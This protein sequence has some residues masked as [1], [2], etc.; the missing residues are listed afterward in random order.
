MSDSKRP[1]RKNALCWTVLIDVLHVFRSGGTP[2]MLAAVPADALGSV[3]LSDALQK[4]PTDSDIIAE[5]R[6]GRLLPGEGEL[7]LVA[8]PASQRCRSN[9]EAPCL[10]AARATT[11]R[12]ISEVPSNIRKMRAS[13]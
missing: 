10:T 6:E 3:Q 11:T 5:A 4:D 8:P 7:P 12:C 2:E 9:S 13:R 1:R